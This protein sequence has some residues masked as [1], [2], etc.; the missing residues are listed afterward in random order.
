MAFNAQLLNKEEI[1]DDR[2]AKKLTHECKDFERLA[3]RALSGK[4]AQQLNI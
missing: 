4:T 1:Q 2:Q 3:F